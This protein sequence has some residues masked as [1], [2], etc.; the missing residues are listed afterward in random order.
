MMAIALLGLLAMQIMYLEKMVAMRN[1]HFSENVMR[2]LYN[3]SRMLEQY[4]TKFFL[5]KDLAE[6]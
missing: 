1:S 2:S 3:V 4:E 5:D 6:A